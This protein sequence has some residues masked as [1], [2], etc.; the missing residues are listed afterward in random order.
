MDRE[1]AVAFGH[2]LRKLRIG[3]G[4]TQEELGLRAEL[5][6]KH[7]SSLE[8]GQKLPNIATVFAL[9]RALGVESHQIMLQTQQQLREPTIGT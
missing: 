9:A 1:L 6:R 4:L 8:L 5:Q 3:A 2:A 7:I